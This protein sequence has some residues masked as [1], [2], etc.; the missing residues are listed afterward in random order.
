MPNASCLTKHKCLARRDVTFRKQPVFTWG[1]ECISCF[2][3]MARQMDVFKPEPDVDIEPYRL[4]PDGTHVPGTK[5]KG[6][7]GN[8]HLRSEHG[9][10]IVKGRD[11][12]GYA[13][14]QCEKDRRAKYKARRK[15]CPSE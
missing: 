10:R 9:R 3:G 2:E 7:C 15:G 13:C 8:G 4:R 14:K 5:P 1:E 11:E 6:A 12:G